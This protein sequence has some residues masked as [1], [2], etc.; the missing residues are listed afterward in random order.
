VTDETFHN[1]I[2]TSALNIE[3]G[4]TVNFASE[5]KLKLK[6]CIKH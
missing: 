6:F 5:V 4:S 1:F 2:H 3:C